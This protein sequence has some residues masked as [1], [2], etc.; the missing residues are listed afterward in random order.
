VALNVRLVATD[1]SVWEGEAD[2]VLL[3]TLDGDLGVLQGHTP[4]LAQLDD[5]RVAF[6]TAEG[7]IEAAVHGGFA[8]VDRNEVIIMS[9]SAELAADIDVARA[10]RSLSEAEAGSEDAK[11]AE[12]RLAVAGSGEKVRY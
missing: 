4:L 7:R 2:F 8:I 10:Q 9:S 11:R 12:V 5:S 1:R 6:E 3:R